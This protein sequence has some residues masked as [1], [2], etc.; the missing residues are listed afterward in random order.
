MDRARSLGIQADSGPRGP[1][2]ASQQLR[3][4]PPCRQGF[5]VGFPP[6]RVPHL[7]LR[8]NLL[9][10]PNGLCQVDF[11]NGEPGFL[12]DVR[13]AI[14]IPNSDTPYSFVWMDLRAE[15]VVLSVPAVDPK[16]YFSVQH[17]LEARQDF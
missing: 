8:H 14:V 15:P 11:R 4:S 12:L 1:S 9:P 16:R 3:W 10:R 5:A 6:H 2:G 7:N 13:Q 17:D